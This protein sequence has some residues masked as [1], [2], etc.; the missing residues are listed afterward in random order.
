MYPLGVKVSD[1]SNGAFREATSGWAYSAPAVLS[2]IRDK[3]FPLDDSRD[4]SEYGKICVL[5]ISGSRM[6]SVQFFT[7]L[8]AGDHRGYEHPVVVEAIQMA[9]RFGSELLPNPV[10]AYLDAKERTLTFIFLSS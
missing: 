4:R 5:V 7:E 9:K 6:S 10:A 1:L 3:M 8:P 2:S